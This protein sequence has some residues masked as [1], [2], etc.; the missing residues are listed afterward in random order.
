MFL[1]TVFYCRVFEMKSFDSLTAILCICMQEIAVG[2]LGLFGETWDRWV[3][4]SNEA[5]QPNLRFL[6]ENAMRIEK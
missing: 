5:P 3:K 2:I 6:L 4:N 1:F